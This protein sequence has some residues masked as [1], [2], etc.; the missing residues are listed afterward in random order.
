MI[1]FMIILIIDM[2]N[3]AWLLLQCTVIIIIDIRKMQYAK[4][5]WWWWSSLTSG[6]WEWF[7]HGAVNHPVDYLK[8]I[9]FNFWVAFVIIIIIIIL[10]IVIMI[11]MINF[12]KGTEGLRICWSLEVKMP[13]GTKP[14]TPMFLIIMAGHHRYDDDDDDDAMWIMIIWTRLLTLTYV[15]FETILSQM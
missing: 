15:I 3:W 4:L 6:R 7:C 2:G 9:G 12:I 14:S 13:S 11:M 5:W 8:A 1:T 10:I